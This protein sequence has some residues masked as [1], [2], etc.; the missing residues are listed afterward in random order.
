MTM[1]KKLSIKKK[2]IIG[3]GLM[4]A[5]IFLSSSVSFIMMNSLVGQLRQTLDRDVQLSEVTN[6]TL[7]TVMSL[8]RREHDIIRNYA[9]VR[10]K[11]SNLRFQWE[12]ECSSMNSILDVLCV[13]LQRMNRTT[14]LSFAHEAKGYLDSNIRKFNAALINLESGNI[15]K[16]EDVAIQFDPALNDEFAM[17]FI[18]TNISKRASSDLDAARASVDRVAKLSRITV[19]AGAFISIVI[20]AIVSLLV[21]FGVRTPLNQLVGNLRHANE[22]LVETNSELECYRKTAEKDMK[23]AI[24]VQQSMLQPEPP[25]LESGWDISFRFIPK[26]GV[27]GDFYEFYTKGD[28]LLGVGIFDVSGHGISSG[29]ITMLSKSVIS[30][31][32]M[33]GLTDPLH[34]VMTRINTELIQELE[35]VDNYLTGILLRTTNGAVEYANAGHTELL[36]RRKGS[37][38]VIVQPN[39][40]DIKGGFLGVSE[41]NTPYRSVS[42][43]TNR[44]DTLILY[45][46]CIIETKNP[47]GEPFGM[48][49]L[50]SVLNASGEDISSDLLASEIVSAIYSFSGKDILDDDL[51]LIIMKKC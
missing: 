37:P 26:T 39:N 3:F 46:D 15:R 44:D 35:S 29:L 27:S 38:A 33:N 19:A 25:D 40:D 41:M 1:L 31:S 48:E 18:I 32:F 30:H 21:A 6:S 2:L 51:S 34:K 43:R 42:F 13:L 16:A 36:V 14:D 22:L 4:L 12:S 10:D 11:D 20:G 45:S 9:K 23:I 49:R 17:E 8:G 47:D 24:N 50:M 5:I 7:A 28:S